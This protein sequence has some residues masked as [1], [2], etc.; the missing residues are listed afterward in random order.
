[1]EPGYGQNKTIEI[2]RWIALFPIAFTGGIIIYNIII[3]LNMIAVELNA[4]PGSFFTILL[5]RCIGD[6]FLGA[7][8]VFIACVIAPFYKRQL[9][10]LMAC[11]LTTISCISLLVSLLNSEYKGMFSAFSIIIGSVSTA[12]I[13]MKKEKERFKA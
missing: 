9:T 2:I 11:I 10:L 4:Y 7:A 8:T 6:Y 1:M 12:Y 3:A 13:I 5:G